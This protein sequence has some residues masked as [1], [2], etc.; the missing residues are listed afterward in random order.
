MAKPHYSVSL[1]RSFPTWWLKYEAALHEIQ[2]R[3]LFVCIETAESTILLR[4]DAIGTKA[5][6]RDERAHIAHALTL[7]ALLKKIL[8]RFWLVCELSDPNP[9]HRKS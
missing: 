5:K 8:F 3:R 6:H 1:A 4:R 2:P 9:P 7:L